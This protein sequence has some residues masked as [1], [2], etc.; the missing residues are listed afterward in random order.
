MMGFESATGLLLGIPNK[1]ENG[2]ELSQSDTEI[3]EMDMPD[4]SDTVLLMDQNPN[5][6]SGSKLLRRI[7]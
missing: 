3:L 7:S 5:L 2:I 6:S 1:T 4:T